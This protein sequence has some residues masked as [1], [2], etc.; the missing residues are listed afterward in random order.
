MDEGGLGVSGSSWAAPGAA[1]GWKKAQPILFQ[2]AGDFCLFLVVV[3]LPSFCWSL[4][5]GRDGGEISLWAKRGLL[6]QQRGFFGAPVLRNVVL[7]P[8]ERLGSG[9][10]SRGIPGGA[11]RAPLPPLTPSS[12]PFSSLLLPLT[13]EFCLHGPAASSPGSSHPTS[14]F[15]PLCLQLSLPSSPFQPQLPGKGNLVCFEDKTPP[16]I[17][18]QDLRGPHQLCCAFGHLMSFAELLIVTLGP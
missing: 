11:S 2:L 15:P 3:P 14:G 5:R 9:N 8:L 10:R 6:E 17:H 4:D 7:V 1:P 18:L 12:V 13:F 16:R